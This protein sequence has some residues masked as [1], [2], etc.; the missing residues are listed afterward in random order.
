MPLH[1]SK[2][3]VQWGNTKKSTHSS[4][5]I[6]RMPSAAIAELCLCLV[7]LR[8]G[9]IYGNQGE[10]WELL[11]RHLGTKQ[12][13]TKKRTYGT[14]QAYINGIPLDDISGNMCESVGPG[15]NSR[16]GNGKCIEQGRYRCGRNSVVI[17]RSDTVRTLIPPAQRTCRGFDWKGRGGGDQKTKRW[18]SETSDRN[19]G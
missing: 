8:E 17:D 18:I 4:L 3:T 19:A 11:V 13:G 16:P 10:G 1:R 7:P 12:S 6:R 14:Y 9:N 2:T 15:D 5:R